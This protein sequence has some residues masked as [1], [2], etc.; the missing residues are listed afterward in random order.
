MEG[1]QIS[2]IHDNESNSSD[3]SQGSIKAVGDTHHY[4]NISSVGGHHGSIKILTQ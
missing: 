3:G 1:G 2:S 4:Q